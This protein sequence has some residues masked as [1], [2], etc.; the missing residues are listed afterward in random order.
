[1]RHLRASRD[2]PDRR[3]VRDVMVWQLAKRGQTWPLNTPLE[4]VSGRRNLNDPWSEHFPDLVMGMFVDP[5][6][7]PD[8][9]PDELPSRTTFAQ[10]QR[11]RRNPTGSSCRPE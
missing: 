4:A 3:L 6:T 9:G 2:S 8:P 7:H 1:V 11:G 5:R 10:V